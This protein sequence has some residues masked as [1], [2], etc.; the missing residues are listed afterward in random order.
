MSSTQRV[1]KYAAI[2]L[3]IILIAGIISTIV[4]AVTTLISAFDGGEHSGDYS[5]YELDAEGLRRLD[6]ELEAAD[7]VIETGESLSVRTDSSRVKASR[8]GETL[9]IT[10]KKS[11]GRTSECEVILTLPELHLEQVD[12]EM[13]AGVL[14][15]SK[16]STAELKLD[17]GAGETVMDAVSVSKSTEINGGAGKITVTASELGKLS[18]DMGI[19]RVTVTASLADGSEIDCGVGALELTLSGSADDYVISADK[20]LGDFTVGGVSVSDG[21]KLGNGNIRVDIDSGIGSVSVNFE[22]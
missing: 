21:S 19:G 11:F 18:F 4:N 10:E 9:R 17:L 5:V 12:V 13:G 1:I 16:L 3:A 15:I 7:L 2:A 8:S 6:V 14:N 22:E 20:G